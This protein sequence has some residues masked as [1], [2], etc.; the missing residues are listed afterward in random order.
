MLFRYSTDKKGRPVKKAIIYTKEE[1]KIPRERID[2][3]AYWIVEHLKNCGYEAYIV[4]GAVRDLIIGKTPKDF[5]IVTS[6]TPSKIKRLFKNSRIIGKRFRL[7]HVFFGEKIFEV[8]TFRS[9]KEGSVGNDFGTMDEDVLRRDFSLNAL[10]YDP[11]KEQVVDYVGGVEDIRN[12]VL[13]PVIP[14]DRIF[15]EDPVRM[16]RAVKYGATTG[17]RLPHSLKK[18]IRSSA[19]LLSPVSPSRLS[20]P[21]AGSLSLPTHRGTFENH[22]RRPFIRDCLRRHRE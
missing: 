16:L 22:K 7:V 17:C 6:A 9:I 14:L 2:A 12:K 3:N 8:S 1:H 11:I 13:K 4:G 21:S 10:Y 5:D 19:Q 20:L 18:K 15:V